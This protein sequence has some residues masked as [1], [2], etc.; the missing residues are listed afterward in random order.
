M[1]TDAVDGFSPADVPAKPVPRQPVV[2]TLL[3]PVE[4]KR[5]D[6]TVTETITELQMGRMDGGAMRRV[7]NAQGKAGDFTAALVCAS[8]RIAPSTF[9]KLD[10]EDAMAAFEVA[11]GFLGNGPAIS[12]M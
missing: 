10:A 4:L 6:G 9:D 1:S 3:F 8:A 7:M 11:S 5:A 12:M 2:Y